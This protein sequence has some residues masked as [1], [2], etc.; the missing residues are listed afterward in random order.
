MRKNAKLSDAPVVDV[1]L[2]SMSE[3]TNQEQFAAF[4]ARAGEGP[5][6]MLNLLEFR[7]EGGR[8][9]YMEYMTHVRPLLAKVGGQAVFLGQGAELLIGR[10][11][12]HW[13]LVLLIQYP[14]RQA[15][16]DMVTSAEYRAI[17]HYRDESL[18]RSVLL[19]LDSFDPTP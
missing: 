3:Q 6:T 15:L 4:A 9:S 13:D 14:K 2:R 11:D 5:V 16:L 10:S 19:A 17:Q 7:A 1:G 12:E 8:A 18:Q